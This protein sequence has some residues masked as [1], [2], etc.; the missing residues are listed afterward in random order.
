MFS[1]S[2]KRCRWIAATIGLLWPLATA[3]F[4]TAQEPL[5]TSAS[6]DEL[7]EMRTRLADFESRLTKRDESDKK[8]AD[9]AKKKFTVRPFGRIHVDAASFHQDAANKAT[10]GDANNGADIRRARLGIEGDGFDVF[11]YRFDVDFVTFDQS[12]TTRPTI[13]DAYLDTKEVPFFGNVR[14][15]HFREPFSL[16]RLDS[17]N[18]LPFLERTAVV[19][20]LTP[21]RNLGLMTFDWNE[22]ETMTWAY[23][24]FD[25]NTNEFG[26]DNRDRTGVAGTG[27]I[28]CLPWSNDDNSELLHFGASYSYRKLGLTQRRFNQRPEVILKEG[29]GLVTPNFVDTGTGA[30][31]VNISDYHVAGFEACTVL[32]PFSL[33]GEY[34]FLAGQQHNG[35]SLFLD[36]GYIEAMYWLTGEHRNYNRKQGI[37][38]AVTPNSTFLQQD[39]N[40]CRTGLGAFE[41]TARVSYLD[42]DHKNVQG[43]KLTDITFGLNWYYT[44]RSRVMFNYIHAF[45]DRNNVN[46]NADILA[47]RFQYAF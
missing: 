37:F 45:L 38:G 1:F 21:F 44:I 26:E 17:T 43:G 30:K 2:L 8:A 19:N 18:D 4:V 3:S 39:Q 24:I 16:E 15:G 10:V 13:F 11:S 29:A 33:Q 7:A 9:A 46:S 31:L 22:S 14:A 34:V 36:G 27:R 23:G 40:G 42:L 5:P 47:V 41:A 6:V 35:N 25:E 12:T 32:G 20:T 28:T